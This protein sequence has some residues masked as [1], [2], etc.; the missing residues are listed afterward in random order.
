MAKKATDEEREEIKNSIIK[1][2]SQINSISDEIDI[3]PENFFPDEH[4]IP[5]LNL[6][7]VVF[8]YELEKQKIKSE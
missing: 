1:L 5:G 3:N 6:D 8:D 7:I 2:E 4:D